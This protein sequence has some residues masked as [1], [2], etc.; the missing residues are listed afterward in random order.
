MS[1]RF[2]SH[3]YHKDILCQISDTI[4]LITAHGCF[5]VGV[6]V[7]SS[8]ILIWIFCKRISYGSMRTMES[9]EVDYL[10][11]GRV[12]MWLFW[13]R[14]CEGKKIREGSKPSEATL[15]S[16]IWSC[17]PALHQQSILTQGT[18]TARLLSIMLAL[19][20]HTAVHWHISLHKCRRNLLLSWVQHRQFCSIDRKLYCK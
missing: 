6:Y 19:L 17:A 14:K 4:R 5:F 9:A 10:S 18:N 11:A 15:A 12:I 7:Y 16:S 8:V 1:T 3:N 13:A 2:A 20:L